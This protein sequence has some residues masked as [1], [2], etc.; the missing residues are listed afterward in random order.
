MAKHKALR[1]ASQAGV[2]LGKL[3]YIKELSY[4]APSRYVMTS[5][6]RSGFNSHVGTKEVSAQVIARFQ[7]I[8]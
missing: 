2:T 6:M 4:G 7:L 1:M 8:P 5:E 3:T